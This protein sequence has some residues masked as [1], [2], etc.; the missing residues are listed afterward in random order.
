[1]KLIIIIVIKFIII[2]II[3]IIIIIII[4]VIVVVVIIIFVV[5]I[6]KLANFLATLA[7][8]AK[9]AHW[10]LLKLWHQVTVSVPVITLEV[11]FCSY[12]LGTSGSAAQ[13]GHWADSSPMAATRAN[14]CRQWANQRHHRP[15]DGMLAGYLFL[16][17]LPAH[18]TNNGIIDAFS[19]KKVICH[20]SGDF[21]QIRGLYL[22][23]YRRLWFKWS[24]T[25]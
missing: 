5:V 7:W 2:I 21:L 6:W 14:Q 3:T 20:I 15:D 4:I 11:Q 18:S 8:W 16:L 19:L 24:F 9:A 13:S 25:S 1:M 23:S 22:K 12:R 17:V 10:L